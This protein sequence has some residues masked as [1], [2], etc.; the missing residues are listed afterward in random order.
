MSSR[1]DL[2]IGTVTFLLT[3]V[4]DSTKPS[5]HNER[6]MY[7]CGSSAVATPTPLSPWSCPFYS[8]RTKA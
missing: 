6:V 8:F 3:D 7:D 5:G 2:P 4:E 1:S